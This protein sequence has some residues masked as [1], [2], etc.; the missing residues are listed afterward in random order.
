MSEENSIFEDEEDIQDNDQLKLTKLSEIIIDDKD[1]LKE[2]KLNKEKYFEYGLLEESED[3]KLYANFYPIKFTKP[4]QI[5]GYPFIIKP[6]CHEES[7]ILK[8]L[9]EASPWPFKKYG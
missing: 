9:R 6:E 8:I 5:C 1:F 7:V 4:I 2:I 3:I